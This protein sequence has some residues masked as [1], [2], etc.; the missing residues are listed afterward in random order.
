MKSLEKVSSFAGNTFAIW[1]LLFGVISFIFP[2]GFS[3]IAPHISLLLGIIMF[4]MGLTLTPKDFKGVIKAPK[5]VLI[6]VI[7]QY[8]IMPFTAYGLAVLFQLPPA[9]AVGVI[10]VGCCPGGT[11]SNVMT[12]LAKGNTALSVSVTTIST[13]IAPIMTPALTLLLAS[14]WMAVSFTSMFISIIQVVL[15]PIVLGV[16]VRML[17]RN[18]VEKSV[19]VLPLVSVIGI[20]AVASAVVAI[21]TEAIATSGLFIF[22]VVVLHNLIGLC[23]GFL[24]AKLF[25]LNFS[26]QKAISIEVGMQNSGLASTLALTAFAATPVAAVPSAIFSVWHNISGPLLATYWSKRG[27]KDISIGNE[28]VQNL[29]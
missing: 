3:W 26:E 25:K 5:S 19:S 24:I 29:G 17:F 2:S 28:K 10:L 21:N 20:V 12:Y 15:L 18:Q 13:L 1:V 27:S 22:G 16:G 14:E 11:A 23:L 7:L 9:I 4:G 6:A 8:T